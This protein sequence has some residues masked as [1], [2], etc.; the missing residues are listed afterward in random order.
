MFKSLSVSIV[1]YNT[2]IKDLQSCLRSLGS[3]P[4]ELKI[5]LIDNS[6]LNSLSSSIP[7]DIDFEYTHVPSNPGYGSGHN[8]AIRQSFKLEGDFHLV[9]NADVRFN[10][11]VLSPLIAHMVNHENIGLIM[12]KVLNPDGGLQRLCKLVPSPMDLLFR[13]FLPRWISDRNNINFEMHGSGYDKIMFVPYLS[14]CFMLLR[15][16]V[17]KD[18][19]LFDERFFMYPEDIDLTRRIATRYDTIFYPFVSVVHDHGAASYKSS[20][21]LVVHLLNIIK[22]F[23]KW[24]WINDPIRLNLNNKAVGQF[25]K[26]E[27]NQN[28]F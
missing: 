26:S 20:K 24:G 16:S 1:L 19:G 25:L 8:I 18:V 23:N 5:Y 11:D 13:R 12:P 9:I 28:N 2:R 15:K 22:Y 7:K 4:G 10:G 17:L 6:P 27:A 14:G 21:M 3:F